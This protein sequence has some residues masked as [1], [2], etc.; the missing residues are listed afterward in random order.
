MLMN[1]EQTSLRQILVVGPVDDL[2]AWSDLLGQLGQITVA[3]SL[4][5]AWGLMSDRRFDLIVTPG[6]ELYNLAHRR[7]DEHTSTILEALGHSLVVIDDQGQFVWSNRQAERLSAEVREKIADGCREII[8]SFATTD[9]P[10]NFRFYPRHFTI[11][12]S[13]DQY[14]DVAAAPIIE[15]DRSIHQVTAL[16]SDISATRRLQ[17][18]VDAIDRA[19]RELVRLDAQQ[20]SRLD[21]SERLA[22]M[23]EKIIRYTR[24]LMNFSNFGIWILN[25]RTNQLELLINVDLPPERVTIPLYASMENNGLCGY[26]AATGRSYICPD[27]RY[28]PRYLQGIDDARSSLTVP[29]RLHDELLG[30]MNVESIKPDAFSEDDRQFAEIFGR[31]IAMALN[32]LDLLV[33]ERV[34]TTGQMATNVL[35]EIAGPLNDILTDTATLMEQYIGHDELR[36]R[37]QAISENINRVKK[38]VKQTTAPTD[39]ILGGVTTELQHDEVLTGRRILVADD[40]SAIRQTICQVLRAYGCEVDAAEHGEEAIHKLQQEN[41]DLVLSDIRMPGKNGY[42]VFAAAKQLHPQCAV[43]LMTGF[44]YDPNHSII[45]AQREGLAGVLFKPFKVDQL[46]VDLRRALQTVST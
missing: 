31:Y 43:L 15:P 45:R 24:D 23:E 35:N 19:G 5:E 9:Q 26:V 10:D 39:G 11:R 3:T 16:I 14:F 33:R 1:M 7:I 22:L 44:G 40:E 28:D 30:V 21:F 41:Y 36:R 17:R 32:T 38:A 8:D 29:L 34:T 13:G 12:V 18:K 4:E 37:L 46:L 27:V 6:A 25:R 42:E 20:L 2:T